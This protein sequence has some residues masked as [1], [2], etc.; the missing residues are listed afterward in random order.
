MP[1]GAAEKWH[2]RTAGAEKETQWMHI[3]EERERVDTHSRGGREIDGKHACGS[4]GEEMLNVHSRGRASERD[5]QQMHTAG[6][7]DA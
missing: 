3:S 4:G 1:I 5:A 6:V 2:M 7:R